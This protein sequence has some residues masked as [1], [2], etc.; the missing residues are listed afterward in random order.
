MPARGRRAG[1]HPPLGQPGGGRRPGSRRCGR[2]RCDALRDSLRDWERRT[3]ARYLEE[4]SRERRL[5]ST[6]LKVVDS[7]YLLT[8]GVEF[9]GA[10]YVQDSLPEGP[11]YLTGSLGPRIDAAFL[12]GDAY[13]T[14]GIFIGME[15]SSVERFTETYNPADGL[16]Y[17]TNREGKNGI[18]QGGEHLRRLPRRGRLWA[19]GGRASRRARTGTDGVPDNGSG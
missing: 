17:N 8:A 19:Q 18:P 9:W 6:R 11:R 1:R 10:G 5:A 16:P 14:S 4:F 3:L 12:E 15:R 13:I 2:R 7:A